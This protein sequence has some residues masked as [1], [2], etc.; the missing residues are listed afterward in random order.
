M[1]S[2]PREVFK[3]SRYLGLRRSRLGGEIEQRC[4]EAQEVITIFETV[5]SCREQN[6]F[7][8]L[9]RQCQ[10]RPLHFAL[11]CFILGKFTSIL[12]FFNLFSPV[13]INLHMMANN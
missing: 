13:L 4:Q 9:K 2:G 12:C 8:P 1:V 11:L 5:Q 7:A 3:K 10:T 6:S